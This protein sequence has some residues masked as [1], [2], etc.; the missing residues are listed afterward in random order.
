MEIKRY[1]PED[2]VTKLCQIEVL[3]GQGVARIDAF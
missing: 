3:L 2:I 1:S